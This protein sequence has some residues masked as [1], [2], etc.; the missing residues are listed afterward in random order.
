MLL[1]KVII[2]LEV[3]KSV[4]MRTVYIAVQMSVSKW[5]WLDMSLCN[6]WPLIYFFL[7]TSAAGGCFI[8]DKGKVPLQASLHCGTIENNVN[9]WL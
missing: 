9:I 3:K 1:W 8:R 5:A 7:F 4:I 2:F 6:P